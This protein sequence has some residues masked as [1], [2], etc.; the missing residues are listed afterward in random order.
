MSESKGFLTFSEG[1]E[2]KHWAKMGKGKLDFLHYENL[3][4]SNPF[5]SKPLIQKFLKK[6]ELYATLHNFLMSPKISFRNL[7]HFLGIA[8]CCEKILV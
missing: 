6:K 5:V 4:F 8:N 2:M 7:K 3:L 1:I